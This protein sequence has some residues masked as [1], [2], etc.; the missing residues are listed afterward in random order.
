MNNKLI[1]LAVATAMAAPLAAQAEVKV[2]GQL[3][4]EIVSMDGNGVVDGL[5]IEDTRERGTQNSGN[6]GALGFTAS[7]DLGG[8]LKALAKYNMNIRTVDAA[9]PGMRDAYVG[10]SGGFGTV[11]FGRLS[12]PYKSSTV[13]WDPML[14]TGFQA[15]G[16]YGM[17]GSI[18]VAPGVSVGMHNSYADNVVAYANKFG[19]VKFVGAF[20]LDEGDTDGDGSADGDHAVSFSVNAPVGPVEVAV[21][22]IDFGNDL[23]D[24]AAT[25]FGVKYTAGAITVAAQMEDLDKGLGD[26]TQTFLT[27]SYK[28]GANTYSVSYGSNDENSAAV[29]DGQ[30]FMMSAKHAFS[31]TTTGYVGYSFSDDDTANAAVKALGAGMRVKF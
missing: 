11:L 4:A 31:K 3:Q 13:K 12:H 24:A 1:A 8:G 22:Y 27:G 10:L 20:S 28:M 17:T 9:A 25:K 7:E 15:R 6:A 2:A 23:T 5:Y 30:Y 21:A 14:A 26:Y 19:N 16:Q 29:K 18:T